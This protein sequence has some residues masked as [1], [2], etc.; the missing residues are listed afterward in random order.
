MELKPDL[1][2]GAGMNVWGVDHVKTYL[3]SFELKKHQ[4]DFRA[5]STINAL[6]DRLTLTP[7]ERESFRKFELFKRR[8]YEIKASARRKRNVCL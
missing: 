5:I 7:E 4:V 8:S 6:K 1:R 3:K 2:Q